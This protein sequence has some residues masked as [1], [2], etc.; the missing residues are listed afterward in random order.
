MAM[1]PQARGIVLLAVALCGLELL[2]SGCEGR[3]NQKRFTPMTTAKNSAEKLWQRV[4][5]EESYSR[6]A[7]WPGH[8]GIR[9]AQFPHGSFHRIYINRVLYDTLPS[10]RELLP[11]GS[12]VVKEQFNG[13]K[14][15][16]SISVMAKIEGYNPQA[17]DW[18]WASYGLDGRPR[19]A[20]R[21][22]GCIACH[23]GLK[24]NDY[25]MVRDIGRPVRL[26]EERARGRRF[27]ED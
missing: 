15:K 17:G 9:R 12:V 20:G 2:L 4:T 1:M 22:A 27:R 19:V 10:E 13:D 21:V 25:I 14:K 6:Y 11:A 5:V 3:T 18:F 8:E 16:Q 24:D 26:E 23:A 7:F